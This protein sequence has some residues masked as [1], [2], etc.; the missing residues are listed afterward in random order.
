MRYTKQ[1]LKFEQQIEKLKSRGLLINDEKSAENY[2]SNISYYRLRAYTF[3]FQDNNN[4]GN[5]HHFFRD[6]IHFEDI[7]DLYCFDR[8]LRVLIFNALE[9]IEVALRTKFIYEYSIETGNSHWFVDKNTYLNPNKQIRISQTESVS[10][11][12]FLMKKVSEDVSRSDEDFVQHYKN[13]YS[14]PDLPPAWMTLETLSFGNL[15]KLIAN[16]GCKSEPYKKIALSFGLPASFILKNWIYSFSV[17][18]N[19]CAHHSRIWNR[20]YH[21]ELKMPYNTMFPFIDKQNLDKIYKNKIFAALCC[22]QYIIKIISPQ[23]NFKNNLFEIIDNG[24]NLLNLKDMGFLQGWKN[25]GV[26]K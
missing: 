22:I 20:R 15:S 17:L 7:I 25:F 19:Y 10:A 26:W 18:R 14:S 12:D 24:G 3:P 6:N 23:S 8:R 2:L 11:Y 13:K 9:K 21:V 4:Q 1:P 5:D 16:L